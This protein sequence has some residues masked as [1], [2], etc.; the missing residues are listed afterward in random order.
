M[1]FFLLLTFMC[2]LVASPSF[3]Q[4]VDE[5]G[6][7]VIDAP[8]TGKSTPKETKEAP[9]TA[10][11]AASPQAIMLRFARLRATNKITA[12][13]SVIDAKI[14]I[15]ARFGNLEILARDC[16]KAPETERPE[17][18]ALLDIW[19]RRMD[20]KPVRSFYGWM[21]SSSPSLSILEHP[22]YDITLIECVSQA[23]NP[24][25]EQ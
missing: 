6:G 3:A 11:D 14:G 19:D 15:I 24:D 13:T 22:V 2:I 16:W 12:R 18:A 20:E 10:V 17:N 4:E 1:R 7:L 9:P 21:F 8:K 25:A 23:G 5:E